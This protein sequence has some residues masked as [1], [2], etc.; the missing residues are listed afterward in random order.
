MALCMHKCTAPAEVKQAKQETSAN[1]C[2]LAPDIDIHTA[3]TEWF[4]DAAEQKKRSEPQQVESEHCCEGVL[5]A[6]MHVQCD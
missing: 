5:S 1:R 2:Q 4:S 6:H 3:C